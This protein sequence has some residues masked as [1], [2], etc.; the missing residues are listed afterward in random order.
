MTSFYGLEH[1]IYDQLAR[2]AEGNDVSDEQ[3]EK[4]YEKAE[5]I[6]NKLKKE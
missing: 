5:E 6:L 2:D 3:K 4:E 1:L